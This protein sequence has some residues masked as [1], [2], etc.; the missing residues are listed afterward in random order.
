ML[1]LD[2][3]SL[4]LLCFLG[5]AMP[6]P[7]LAVVIQAT[8]RGGFVQG[9]IAALSH[10]LGVG[11]Y[12]VF[13]VTG[14]AMIMM[15]VP[16]LFMFIQIAG[17]LF[18][19]Y[20]SLKTLLNEAR[21]EASQANSQQS[22]QSAVKGFL[23]AFLNPKL[24]IFFTALFSQ[25]IH[26]GLGLAEKSI[27]VLT[28]LLIDGLWYCLVAWL[29]SRSLVQQKFSSSQIWLERIFSAALMFVGCRLLMLQ[30]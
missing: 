25:F 18:L 8:A 13:T 9:A 22:R 2:W 5:A 27:M 29:M 4:A 30:V 20:L 1:L 23:I 19:I 11:I 14:L 7:S 28:V 16:G 12:A 3:L 15:T 6:G 10:A 26:A 24:L 21:Q 17:A